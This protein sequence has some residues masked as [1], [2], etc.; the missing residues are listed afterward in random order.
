MVDL[1]M[2]FE[3]AAESMTRAAELLS[4]SAADTA[5]A[6]AAIASQGFQATE[7]SIGAMVTALRGVTTK[8]GE[9]EIPR[10]KHS[11]EDV[12]DQ[13]GKI[14]E[15]LRRLSGQL[16]TAGARLSE[17]ALQTSGKLVV[18]GFEVAAHGARFLQ[19]PDFRLL[20]WIPQAITQPYI[21]GIKTIHLGLSTAADLA[22]LCV[23]SLPA[24]GGGL[25]DIAEDLER[26]A[27]LLDASRNTIRDLAGLF[28][29]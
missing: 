1:R 14:A 28:P 22:R 4:R 26:A 10:V 9:I 23:E 15:R 29:I 2:V 8:L 18:D 16:G 6:G 19:P 27:D 17:P 13:L 25:R 5:G 21:D 11:L 12:A 20:H 7:A 24:M 3:Q